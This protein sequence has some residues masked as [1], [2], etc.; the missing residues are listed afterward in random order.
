M[1]EL[2]IGEIDM[3]LGNVDEEQ[4]FEDVLTE[5]WVDSDTMQD[6]TEKL[7]HLGNKILQA[8]ETY[9]KQKELE[10]SLFG[11]KFGAQ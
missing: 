4:E 11:D 1:F 10:D 9:L 5:L 8:K 3:I 7:D 2:V 6:F